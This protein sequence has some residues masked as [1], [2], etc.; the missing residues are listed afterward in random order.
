MILTLQNLHMYC[1][2]CG[3]ALVDGSCPDCDFEDGEAD[4][5]LDD[6]EEYP[7]DAEDD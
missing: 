6:V 1:Q 7:D 4:E 5:D 2:D 3:E